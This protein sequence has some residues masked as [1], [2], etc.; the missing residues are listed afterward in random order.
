M[1][2]DSTPI[3][4]LFQWLMPEVTLLLDILDKDGHTELP[5]MTEQ[6]MYVFQL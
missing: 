6:E 5:K 2:K 4:I 1:N 3:T